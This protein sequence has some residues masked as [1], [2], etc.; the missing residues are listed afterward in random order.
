MIH[1]IAKQLERRSLERAKKNG[2]KEDVE[3][4]PKEKENVEKE[5]KAKFVYGIFKY[6]S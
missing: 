2:V 4:T 6:I 5:I 3:L 1:R